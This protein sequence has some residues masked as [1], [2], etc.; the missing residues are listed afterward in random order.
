MQA[1]YYDPVIGRFYSNDP[2]GAVAH[3]NTQNGIHGF[4]RYAYANNNPYKYIDPDGQSSHNPIGMV[5]WHGGQE[6]IRRTNKFVKEVAAATSLTVERKAGLSFGGKL[7]SGMGARANL[8]GKV[9]ASSPNSSSPEGIKGSFEI[10]ASVNTLS[11]N[12]SIEVRVFE[13]SAIFDPSTGSISD[14]QVE[15]SDLKGADFKKGMS[16]LKADGKLSITVA[17]LKIEIDV[18]K[19]DN[20][21]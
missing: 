11:E 16:G 17:S 14:L 9:S 6:G 18:T 1:R 20:E 8:A 10:N 2:I 4:N 3:L 19:I 21:Q 5:Q 13:A 12:S 7:P 15:G